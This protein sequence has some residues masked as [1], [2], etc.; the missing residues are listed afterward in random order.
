MPLLRGNEETLGPQGV[1][2]LAEGE[3]L[4]RIDFRFQG[5]EPDAPTLGRALDDQ[6]K[7]FSHL[8]ALDEDLLEAPANNDAVVMGHG[9]KAEQAVARLFHPGDVVCHASLIA[10]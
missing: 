7:D 2:Q 10:G 8:V 5:V 1:D 6:V 3:V 4:Q 9:L